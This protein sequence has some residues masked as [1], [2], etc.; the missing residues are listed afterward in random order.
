LPEPK[1]TN[2]SLQFFWKVTDENE[3]YALCTPLFVKQAAGSSL[4]FLVTNTKVAFVQNPDITVP[5][6][7]AVSVPNI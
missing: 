4:S 1:Q 7:K 2:L 6:T 3:V 5:Y